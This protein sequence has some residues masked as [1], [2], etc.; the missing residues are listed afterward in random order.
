[1][2]ATLHKFDASQGS[3]SG[4]RISCEIWIPAAARQAFLCLPGLWICVNKAK[5]QL[6][7]QESYS[8]DQH[9]LEAIGGDVWSGLNARLDVPEGDAESNRPKTLEKDDISLIFTILI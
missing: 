6:N 1:M 5:N 9:T 4:L 8:L 7:S 2:I 3:T